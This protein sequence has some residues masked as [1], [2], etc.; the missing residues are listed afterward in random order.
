MKKIILCFI[1]FLAFI[2]I[3]WGGKGGKFI[4]A[5]PIEIIQKGEFYKNQ[6]NILNRRGPKPCL[7][8][9]VQN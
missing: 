4:T 2:V 8:N 7:E 3:C 1:V 9:I 5:I 6:M